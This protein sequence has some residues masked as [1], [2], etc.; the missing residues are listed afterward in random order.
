MTDTTVAKR[1]AWPFPVT[2]LSF[3]IGNQNLHAFGVGGADEI[4]A[5]GEKR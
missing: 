3:E 4:D 1:S 2:L 5:K